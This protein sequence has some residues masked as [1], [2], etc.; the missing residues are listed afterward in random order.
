METF[1]CF[2]TAHPDHQGAA[3][4]RRESPEA[5]ALRAA[6]LDSGGRLWAVTQGPASVCGRCPCSRDL[7]AGSSAT[8]GRK[9]KPSLLPVL[10]RFPC[11]GAGN[12]LGSR[13]GLQTLAG[14]GRRKPL[15]D[16][17]PSPVSPVTRE[18]IQ[19]ARPR[20]QK[21]PQLPRGQ[22]CPSPSARWRRR[23]GGCVPGSPSAQL[24]GFQSRVAACL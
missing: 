24:A 20:S 2:H 15:M 1:R 8:E 17:L 7:P 9:W 19:L 6:L 11:W 4:R 14:A 3:H 12:R 21:E 22:S 10:V 5:M 16:G 23:A 13:R 18:C